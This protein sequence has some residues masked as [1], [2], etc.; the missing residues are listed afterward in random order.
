MANQSEIM[1]IKDIEKYVYEKRVPYLVN[2]ELLTGC[3]LD[4]VHCY[5]PKHDE[6]KLSYNDID[7]IFK[8]LKELGT[9]IIV[10]TGGEIFARKDIFDIIERARF[11]GFRIILFTNA[12][13]LNPKKI[14]RLK[15]L[16]VY[17]VSTSIY[18][19]DSRIHDLI[20][21]VEGALDRTLRNIRLIKD[22]GINVEVKTP[23]M[24]YNKDCFDD[25]ANYCKDNEYAFNSSTVIFG[26]TD[27]SRTNSEI[28]IDGKDLEVLTEKKDNY[29]QNVN[30]NWNKINFDEEDY[31]CN[32]LRS[33]LGID[34]KG[35]VYPC[36][37]FPIKIGNIREKSLK[38]IWDSDEEKKIQFMKK[39]DLK[40]CVDCQ[41][42][43]YCDICPG[44]SYME[45]K[46]YLGCSE[47]AKRVATLRYNSAS[48]REKNYGE[49]ER[50]ERKDRQY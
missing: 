33:T 28:Q 48:E 32:D 14:E 4:C 18:S 37:S 21:T 36:S 34:S 25:I 44:L 50:K 40:K 46:D 13:L 6:Q 24:I 38:D 9:F 1:T 26:T 17:E 11:Y 8:Q 16:Y 41:K 15:E 31:I 42:V 45:T 30:S 39:R 7:N 49:I 3:N 20:T 10:L 23:F 22:V 29:S 19:L 27:G 12:T 43:K 2:I 5:I 35:D 47:A